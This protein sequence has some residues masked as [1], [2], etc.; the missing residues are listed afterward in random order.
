MPAWP[1]NI[2]EMRRER[3]E[4]ERTYWY[5]SVCVVRVHSYLDPTLE[6]LF[7][8]ILVLVAALE[9]PDSFSRLHSASSSLHNINVS[10]RIDINRRR[11]CLI[12]MI[13]TI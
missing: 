8:H 4:R 10:L 5:V 13:C 11:I 7:R 1:A 9:R 12:S 6:C 2:C 3:E